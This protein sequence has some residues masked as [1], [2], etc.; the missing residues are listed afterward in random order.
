MVVFFALACCTNILLGVLV[1]CPTESPKKSED[2]SG[3][4]NN[5]PIPKVPNDEIPRIP[6]VINGKSTDWRTEAV[7][8]DVRILEYKGADKATIKSIV[9]PTLVDGKKFWC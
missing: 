3:D 2:K 7:G 9:I 6:V 4:N 1:G 8:D 5:N